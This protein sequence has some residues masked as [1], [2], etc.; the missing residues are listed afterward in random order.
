MWSHL[1]MSVILN[2]SSQE[3]VFSQNN[4]KI[5]KT[6]KKLWLHQWKCF[7]SE[8]QKGRSWRERNLPEVCGEYVRMSSCML[9]DHVLGG[10]DLFSDAFAACRIPQAW[11]P[12]ENFCINTE[13]HHH[14]QK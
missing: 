13:L 11:A 2:R 10:S 9:Q 5:K 4:K 8:Q 14:G 1:E 7:Q 6:L 12:Q 3:N